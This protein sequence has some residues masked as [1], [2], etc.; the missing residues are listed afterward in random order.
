MA[1]TLVSFVCVRVF[2]LLLLFCPQTNGN[3]KNIDG[4]NDVVQNTV[5]T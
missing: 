2:V 3:L 1:F 5:V 4:E